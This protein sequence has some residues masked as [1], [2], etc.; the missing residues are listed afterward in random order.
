M[1][2]IALLLTFLPVIAS[3]QQPRPLHLI[4]PPGIAVSEADQKQL[5]AGL[6]R[7]SARLEALRSNPRIADVEIFHKAV[8]YA[9]EGN[10]FFTA[11]DVFKAKELLRIANERAADLARGDAPWAKATGLVVRGYVS[12]ID[13]SVQPYGLVVPPS[14]VARPTAQMARGRVVSR[15][16]R[17]LSE[18]NFLWDRIRNPGEFT[19]RDTIV[20]HLYGRYCN[21]SKF[22]GEV[23]FFEALDDVKRNYAVDENRILVRGFSMGGASAWHFGAHYGTDFAAVAPGAGFAE[24]W[25]FTGQTRRG[26]KPNGSKR[27]SFISPTQRTT[28]S[29]SSMFRSSPTTAIRTRRNRRPT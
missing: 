27:N 21:A 20:L 23:D 9:L 3:A 19:P 26:I 6:D 28:Q 29:I 15:P 14:Y 1:K 25:S 2:S 13:R 24:T 17:D 8:R 7:L 10:E 5:R 16:Q 18:V 12:K 11:E 22:A 4:P